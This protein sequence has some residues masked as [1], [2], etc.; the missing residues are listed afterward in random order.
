MRKIYLLINTIFIIVIVMLLDAYAKNIESSE[1]SS[2]Q[3]IQIKKQV[4]KTRRKRQRKVVVHDENL[5]AILKDS[6]LF[7]VNRGEE[8]VSAKAKTPTPRKN[9]NFKLMGV[10]LFGKLKGAIITCSGR[11]KKSSGKS[12]FTI[13]EDVGDG[14]KLYEVAAKTVVLKNGS[15]KISL[16]LAKADSKIVRPVRTSRTTSRRVSRRRT[17]RIRR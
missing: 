1:K 7:E 16:E 9:S 2:S 17:S 13:G 5:V 14:Y 12:Y 4:K 15:R 3:K 8:I 10:C 6:N 11:S